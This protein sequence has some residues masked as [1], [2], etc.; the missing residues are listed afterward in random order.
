MCII[1][2]RYRQAR[3]R[4]AAPHDHRILDRYMSDVDLPRWRRS[5]ADRPTPEHAARRASRMRPA[6]AE[7]GRPRHRRLASADEPRDPVCDSPH[8]LILVLR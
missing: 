8:M 7:V 5:L 6:R 3:T 2:A 1:G 4:F